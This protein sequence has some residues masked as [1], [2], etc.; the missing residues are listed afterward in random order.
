[1][2]TIWYMWPTKNGKGWIVA[3]K[4]EGDM[5]TAF[6]EAAGMGLPKPVPVDGVPVGWEGVSDRSK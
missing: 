2:S 4:I 1:M 3:T 5:S 6:I